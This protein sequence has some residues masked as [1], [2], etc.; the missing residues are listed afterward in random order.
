MS[1]N[2]SL[3]EPPHLLYVAVNVSM[4]L[5]LFIKGSR[6]T[7]Q[8]SRMNGHLGDWRV[9][10]PDQMQVANAI[11]VIFLVKIFDLF[12]YPWL[13]KLYHLKFT[14]DFTR[15]CRFPLVR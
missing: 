9:I 2:V 8:A 13:G 10:L 4:I 6:W 7:F 1:L 15:S 11:L 12:I 3:N 5:Y 14:G